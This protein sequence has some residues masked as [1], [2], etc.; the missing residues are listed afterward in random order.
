MKVALL[1][2]DLEG[3]SS[4]EYWHALGADITICD[5]KTDLSDVPAGVA[6]H[7]GEDYLD[8]LDEFDLLVRT[9][10]LPPHVI[11]KKNPDVGGKITTNV[12]E[13]LRVCPTQNV[14]G[15]TGS[16]GKGTTSTLITK[17]LE[18]AGREVRLGGNIGIPALSFLHELTA[19]SWVVLELSSFQLIDLQHSPHI[20]VCLMMVPEH[21]NWH[22]H[23]TEYVQ[24]KSQLFAHQTS[25]DIAVYF[26]KNDTSREV[27]NAGAGHKFP[28]Y[29]SPG[30]WVNGNMLTMNG[31]AVC[32]TSELKLLGQHNWQNACA[33]ITTTWLAGVRDPETIRSVL[34]SFAGLPYHLELVRELDGV[35]YYNDSFST[36]PETATVAVEALAEPKILVL[37]GSDKNVPFDSLARAIAASNVRRVVLIGDTANAEHPASA[38]KIDA[39]LQAAGFTAI[40]SLAKPGGISMQEIVDTAQDLAQPGDVVLFSP[41]SASFDMFP[42]YK[43]RSA[44]FSHAVNALQ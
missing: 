18:A 37:G 40:T 27:A 3:R 43:V 30:A 44:A 16:K 29:R 25:D 15:V 33:A 17:M 28:Y 5:Q 24:A 38:P 22:A 1:G 6:T 20:G 39:A 9:P 23:F 13:F 19:D 21:L 7:L 11:L 34:T 14:I 8:G 42:N 35:R 32:T 41:A 2:F 4:Y 36:A 10:G 12:N 31:A 26:A